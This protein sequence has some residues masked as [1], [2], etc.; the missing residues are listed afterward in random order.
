MATI[1]MEKYTD[2]IYDSGRLDI[3]GYPNTVCVSH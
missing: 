1:E 2:Y 3:D